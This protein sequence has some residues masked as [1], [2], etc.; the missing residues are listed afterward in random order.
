ML[1]AWVAVKGFKV[2]FSNVQSDEMSKNIVEGVIKVDSTKPPYSGRISIYSK[3]GTFI[4]AIDPTSPVN[5]EKLEK[6]D[7][8]K[9]K[10]NPE[11]SEK[12]GNQIVYYGTDFSIE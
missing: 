1:L 10:F 11:G 5:L 4:G 6:A 2:L 7:G 9:I 8:K 12:I 3:G